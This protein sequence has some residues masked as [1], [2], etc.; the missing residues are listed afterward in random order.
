VDAQGARVLLCITNNQSPDAPVRS[1]GRGE[2]SLAW[3]SR[4]GRGYLVIGHIPE[5]KA[6]DLAPTLEERV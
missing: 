3:W 1:E 5:A 4:G 6:V 2:L